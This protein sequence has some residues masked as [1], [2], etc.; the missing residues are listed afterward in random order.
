MYEG[1]GVNAMEDVTEW[2]EWS[3]VDG[4]SLDKV[5]GVSLDGVSDWSTMEWRDTAGREGLGLFPCFGSFKHA[6]CGSRIMI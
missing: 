3:G 4:L 2:S 5:D 6:L 1:D